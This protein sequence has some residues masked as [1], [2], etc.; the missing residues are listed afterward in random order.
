M[1]FASFRVLGQRPVP[2]EASPVAPE[3]G[4]VL[5][6]FDPPPGSQPGELGRSTVRFTV[7][8][9]EPS[10]TVIAGDSLS[11]IAHRFNTTTDAV[12]GINNLPSS[13]LSVG[14]RLIIP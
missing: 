8:P 7:A 3:A 14:Q 4:E 10:Y 1:L 5:G 11:A 9:I 13:A 12:L 2:I 6:T